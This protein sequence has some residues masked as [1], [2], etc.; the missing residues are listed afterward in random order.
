S[1]KDDT[2]PMRIL[3]L[4]RQASDPPETLP[5]LGA[6]LSEYYSFRGWSEEGIPTAEKLAEL[7]LQ[8]CLAYA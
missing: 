1:R 4:T 6:M 7:G 3:T 2:L 5:H 8:Q